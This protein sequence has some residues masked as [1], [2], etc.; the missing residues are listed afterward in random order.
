MTF[1]L[2]YSAASI[3]M[4]LLIGNCFYHMGDKS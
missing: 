1:Y 2:I 3:L 4:S